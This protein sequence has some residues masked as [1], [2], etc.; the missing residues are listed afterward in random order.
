[1]NVDVQPRACCLLSVSVRKTSTGITCCEV[2]VRIPTHVERQWLHEPQLTSQYRTQIVTNPWIHCH[3]YSVYLQICAPMRYQSTQ[4]CN[5]ITVLAWSP[6]RPI[7]CLGRPPCT[8]GHYSDNSRSFAASPAVI[9]QSKLQSLLLM[10][11]SSARTQAALLR[12]PS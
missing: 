2:C 5:D 8:R 4:C 7:S 6:A 10:P 12:L 1:M 9:D 3:I 11:G